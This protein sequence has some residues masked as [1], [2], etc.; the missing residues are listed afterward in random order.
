MASIC[1]LKFRQWHVETCYTLF[2]KQN[3][4]IPPPPPIYFR[5]ANEMHTAFSP[6]SKH[7]IICIYLS[8]YLST[9]LMYSD[10]FLCPSR[11]YGIR[12]HTHSLKFYKYSQSTQIVFKVL[13]SMSAGRE[14]TAS[15]LLRG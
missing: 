14:T 2:N 10:L 6:V 8:W 9:R 11:I 15:V 1:V 7:L 4:L 3:Q 13:H 12:T 5:K